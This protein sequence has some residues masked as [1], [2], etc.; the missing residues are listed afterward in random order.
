M[1]SAMASFSARVHMLMLMSAIACSTAAAWPGNT[2]YTGAWSVS[3][4]SV[5]VSCNGVTRYEY[6]RGTGRT[7]ER[8]TAVSRPV[9]R[10]RSSWNRVTSPSVA[11]ISRNWVSASS[12]NGTC[13]A[14]PRSGSA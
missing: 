11:D 3:S 1:S 4:S 5:S 9:R 12:S 8:T 13:Q 14:Q 10:V 6:V 2:T 7:A